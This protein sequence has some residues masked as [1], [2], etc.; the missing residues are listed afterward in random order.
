MPVVKNENFF[1]KWY[2]KLFPRSEA[3]NDATSSFV[4]VENNNVENS[5]NT[6]P[7]AQPGPTP[8]PL[9][10][11]STEGE[12]AGT[13]WK[14][15]L[16]SV[17]DKGASVAKSVYNSLPSKEQI[18]DGVGKVVD[19]GASAVKS[20][21]N[22][23]PSGEQVGAKLDEAKAAVK[24]LSKVNSLEGFTEYASE[25]PNVAKAAENMYIAGV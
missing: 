19:K 21:Y 23:L 5:N 14:D 17:T 1:T 7:K 11:G 18:G 16:K 13:T 2:N 12:G 10:Q 15:T 4:P 8:I 25:H 24:D 6:P 9:A 20:V 22:N 3:K